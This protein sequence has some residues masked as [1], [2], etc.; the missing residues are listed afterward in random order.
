MAPRRVRLGLPSP[1]VPDHWQEAGELLLS[2]TLFGS[3]CEPLLQRLRTC[4]VD[5]QSSCRSN[6]RYSPGR[7]ALYVMWYVPSA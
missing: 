2:R 7:V 3:I 1:A 5:F 6:T 4:I